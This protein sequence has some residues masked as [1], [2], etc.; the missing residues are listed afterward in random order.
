MVWEEISV[1][2]VF[3]LHADICNL[4][5][6]FLATDYNMSIL[7]GPGTWGQNMKPNRFSIIYIEVTTIGFSEKLFPVIIII[8]MIIII[9]V[10]YNYY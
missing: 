1:G 7:Q 4:C 6:S 2:E 8:T 9:I 10:F 5:R 3:A